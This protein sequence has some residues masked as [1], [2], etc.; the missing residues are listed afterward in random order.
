MFFSLL[1]SLGLIFGGIVLGLFLFVTLLKQTGVW[2]FL[3]SASF[4]PLSF[5]LGLSTTFIIGNFR[6]LK[7]TVDVIR[8]KSSLAD[9]ENTSKNV[10]EKI[11][12]WP[13]L[14]VL[15]FNSFWLFWIFGFWTQKW[16]AAF[17]ALILGGIF[18]GLCLRY[19]VKKNIMGK[20]M[21]DLFGGDSF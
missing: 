15:C 1:Y 7:K 11:H 2:F 13:F 9:L 20:I 8:D 5:F 3:L 4:Y 17:M 14:L 6:F 18:Y 21:D 19:V 10:G 16:S 12:L